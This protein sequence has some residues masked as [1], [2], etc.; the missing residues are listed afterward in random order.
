MLHIADYSDHFFKYPY[1]FLQFSKKTW[2][3]YL[4]PGDLPGW[5]LGDHLVILQELGLEVSILEEQSDAAAFARI[6]PY[7]SS[8]YDPEDLHIATTQAV[9]AIAR[10]S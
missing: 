8:D 4:N 9:L 1:H 2:N 5:R 10:K 6:R 3:R 7:I